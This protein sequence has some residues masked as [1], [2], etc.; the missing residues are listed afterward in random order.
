MNGY[1]GKIRMWS[2]FQLLEWWL[3]STFLVV[4]SQRGNFKNTNA[5]Y[6]LIQMRGLENDTQLKTQSAT[7]SCQILLLA[8]NL[9]QVP[10]APT[11]YLRM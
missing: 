2:L 4:A 10:I 11:K 7:D 3:Y 5:I 8:K 6:L 9:Q 1:K